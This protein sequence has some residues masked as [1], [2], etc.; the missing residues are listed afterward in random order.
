MLLASADA[1]LLPVYRELARYH[2]KRLDWGRVRVVQAEEYD[3]PELHRRH[4]LATRLC[5]TL[6]GPLRTRAHLMW[7]GGRLVEPHAHGEALPRIDV[8][9]HALGRSGAVGFHRALPSDAA[10]PSRV[11]RLRVDRRDGLPRDVTHGLAL[12]LSEMRHA[13]RTL[14]L[15]TGAARQDDV[16]A[17]MA[18]APS[19]ASALLDPLSPLS[20][21]AVHTDPDAAPAPVAWT[22]P[23][24][25]LSA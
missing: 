25:R 16:Q 10:D 14:I 6:V 12:S 8:A 22:L 2:A 5:E 9:L 18:R 4:H 7:E 11:R 21:A 24:V 1:V 19:P 20:L 15:A 13:R 23:P 17:L 3:A